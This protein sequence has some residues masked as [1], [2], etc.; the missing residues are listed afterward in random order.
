MQMVVNNVDEDLRIQIVDPLTD[1]LLPDVQIRVM[2]ATNNGVISG[3]TDRRGLFFSAGSQWGS[4]VIARRDQGDYAFFRSKV[5]DPR[6]PFPGKRQGQ[7]DA[8]QQ[9]QLND[10]LDNVIQFNG[11]NIDAR[12]RA[13]RSQ[14]DNAKDGI[15]IFQATD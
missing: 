2:S 3:I 8:R 10:Y 9:L 1:E 5:R 7:N 12:D 15:Q 14:V 6:Q 13:W 4:T 11:S